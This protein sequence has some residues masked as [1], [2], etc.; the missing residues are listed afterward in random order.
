MNIVSLLAR[1]LVLHPIHVL[2]K[3]RP[4]GAYLIHQASTLGKRTTPW[5]VTVISDPR[6]LKGENCLKNIGTVATITAVNL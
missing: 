3:Y 5:A 1:V 4:H 2:N 6:S